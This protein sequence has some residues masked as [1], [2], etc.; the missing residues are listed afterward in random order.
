MAKPRETIAS[1]TANAQ[2]NTDRRKRRRVSIYLNDD[3]TPDLAGLTPD[4]K[5]QLGLGQPKPPEPE[6]PPMEIPPAM[7]GGL[8][9]M[10]AR[11][12]AAIV[13]PRVGLTQDEALS[14]LIPPPE[15]QPPLQEAAAR[16][17]AKHSGSLGKWQEEIILGTLIVSWQAQAF[18]AMRQLIAEKAAR[19]AQY[20]PTRDSQPPATPQPIDRNRNR[21]AGPATPQPE[22]EP[23]L[24]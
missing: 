18:A 9:A 20:Q 16:V 14:M 24:V 3:G 6:A 13:A 5:L 11:I 10:L 8:I 1:E 19:E 7:I 4:Q 2:P 23:A 21:G 12:E 17:I 22:P 15:L